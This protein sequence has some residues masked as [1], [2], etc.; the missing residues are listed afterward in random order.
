[1][2]FVQF[3]GVRCAER[4]EGGYIYRADWV[5]SIDEEKREGGGETPPHRERE[6]ERGKREKEEMCVYTL[7]CDYVCTTF[8]PSL[9]AIPARTQLLTQKKKET[10]MAEAYIITIMLRVLKTKGG[11]SSKQMLAAELGGKKRTWGCARAMHFFSKERAKGV[12]SL[13]LPPGSFFPISVLVVIEGRPIM[14]NL[15]DVQ[16]CNTDHIANPITTAPPTT[17]TTSFQ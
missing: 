8:S 14:P 9:I 5:G 17:A 11:K 6:R 1:V 15:A 3:K 16:K 12:D 4:E 2:G 7:T 10:C 13:C